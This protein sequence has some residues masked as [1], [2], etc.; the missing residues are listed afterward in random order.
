MREGRG[1]VMRSRHGLWTKDPTAVRAVD[2]CTPRSRAA[3]CAGMTLISYPD[4]YAAGCTRRELE[5]ALAAGTVRRLRRGIVTD[6]D[7]TREPTDEHLLRM[8]AAA[9]YLGPGTVFSH[10]SA[11]VLHGLSL[12]APRLGEV[13]VVRTLG[14]HGGI[15]PTVHARVARLSPDDTMEI[16]GL[17]V[18]GLDRTVSDLIRLLPFHE[19]VM[20]LD[21]ALA[22]GADRAELHERTRDGRGC[23]MAARALGFADRDAESPGESLSRVRMREAGLV[24]PVLQHT[25]LDAAGRFLGRGD[26]YWDHVRTVGEFDGRVKYTGLAPTTEDLSRVVLAEKRREQQIMDSG[27]R[28]V[29]WTWPDLWDGSM[30]NRLRRIVGT[31]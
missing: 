7:A 21:R 28:V 27:V 26:F 10:Y 18:T 13:T 5:R 17:P 16:D 8:R 11:A 19:S 1:P 2:G 22:V 14:G 24:M 4:W 29:R 3:E 12:L 31:A 25:I 9:T 6:A 15:H 23:R 20:L 30:V